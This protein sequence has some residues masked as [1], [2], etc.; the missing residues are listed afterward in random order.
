MKNCFTTSQ[1][2]GKGKELERS[3]LNGGKLVV[4]HFGR[5]IFSSRDSHMKVLQW[6]QKGVKLFRVA[7]LSQLFI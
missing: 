3:S 5:E 1:A 2:S 6:T 4:V 7:L